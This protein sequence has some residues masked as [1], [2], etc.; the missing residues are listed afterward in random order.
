MLEFM[1]AK[2]G[3][4]HPGELRRE[5]AEQKAERIITEELACLKWTESDLSSRLKSDPGKLAIAALAQERNYPAIEMGCGACPNRHFQRC[6]IGVTSLAAAS[7]QDS[8]R[9]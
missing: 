1:E 8:N 2:L 6:Q 3:E 4:N 7:G 5:T 9:Y